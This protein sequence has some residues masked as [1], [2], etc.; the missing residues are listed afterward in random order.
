MVRNE[1]IVGRVGGEEFLILLPNTQQHDALDIANRLLQTVI[2]YPW[3][4]IAPKLQQSIS[5]GIACYQDEE[6]LS[7]LIKKADNALYQAKDCGRNRVVV[8]PQ[9]Q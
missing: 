1:D 9:K 8:Q 5:A 2:Q 4:K 3:T 6:E 7:Y